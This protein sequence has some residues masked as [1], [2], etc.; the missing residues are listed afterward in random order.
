MLEE[1]DSEQGEP[2]GKLKLCLDKAIRRRQSWTPTKDTLKDK[3]CSEDPEPAIAFSL[4]SSG[5]TNAPIPL[6]HGFGN[7]KGGFRFEKHVPNKS[8][9]PTPSRSLSIEAVTKKRKL[10]LVSGVVTQPPLP[11]LLKKTSS[12][13][14]KP[15]TITAKASAPFMSEKEP[16]A[17]ILNYLDS[18]TAGSA[19]SLQSETASDHHLSV[20]SDKQQLSAKEA[21]T[22]RV[23]VAKTKN[24]IQEPPMVLPPETAMKTAHEQDLMFGTSSQLERDE[25]PTFTRDLQCAIKES[26]AAEAEKRATPT[27]GNIS[28]AS[29]TSSSSI[30]IRLHATSRDLW[31]VAARDIKGSLLCAEVINLTESPLSRPCSIKTTETPVPGDPTSDQSTADGSSEWRSIGTPVHINS[32]MPPGTKLQV[33][34]EEPSIPKSV[35]EASL[36]ERPRSRSPVK[37]KRARKGSKALNP[38]SLP[39]EKPNYKGFTTNDLKIEVKSNGFKPIRRR[40]EMIALLER[41]WESRNRAA[42]QSLPPNIKLSTAPVENPTAAAESPEDDPSKS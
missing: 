17:T 31:S 32:S 38:K 9:H 16:T 34:T 22:R 42:L 10:E 5:T 26:E 24:S 29:S 13:K 25:S 23:P 37:Q 4:S 11:A 30:N 27:R 2:E 33:L 41:C 8:A 28:F 39:L 19:N 18:S 36:K 12:M 20:Q 14:K 15:Q 35:A 7:V 3:S 21:K 1:Q 40:E 6:P